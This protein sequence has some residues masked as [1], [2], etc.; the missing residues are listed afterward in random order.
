VRVVP[1]AL[2]TAIAVML[3]VAT[4]PASGAAEKKSGSASFDPSSWA[5]GSTTTPTFTISNA[6]SSPNQLGSAQLC[7]PNGF[8]VAGSI[9][10]PAGSP[11]ST[12]NVY[13]FFNL[14]IAPGSSKSFDLTVTVPCNASA[15]SVWKL[16]AKQSNDFNGPPGNN[17]DPYPFP[18]TVTYTGSCTLSFFTQP[19]QSA[20]VLDPST[21]PLTSYPLT[22]ED[23]TSSIQVRAT[24]EGGAPIA[25]VPVTITSTAS[26]TSGGG[27]TSTNGSG[28]ASFPNL[29]VGP[30][31]GE[32]TLTASAP[33]F[34][35]ATSNGFFV[36]TV[37]C[38]AS[39][40][41]ASKQVDSSTNVSVTQ[42]GFTGPIGILVDT[43]GSGASSFCGTGGT[44]VGD[45][46]RVEIR[47]LAGNTEITWRYT[48][49]KRLKVPSN[50]Q[51]YELCV[52]SKG[53]GTFPVQSAYDPDH[54]GRANADPF[55]PGRY[56]GVLTDAP[57][58]TKCDASYT[59]PYPTK[60]AEYANG[61]DAIQVACFPAPFDPKGI[62]VG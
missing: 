8:T 55:D 58:S 10:K 52:G 17:F 23:G 53:G 25:G 4:G 41:T 18:I 56:W 9:P 48:K 31:G 44:T 36:F 7:I 2:M 30:D 50:G 61:A 37:G 5:R 14:A 39:P 15:D 62:G 38:T 29:R 43:D 59:I 6:A 1:I 35:S 40:C 46:F 21:S 19:S 32:Y 47:P 28:I 24:T 33:G 34:T 51:T 11:C 22:A 16:Y 27:A 49:D 54:D 57:S 20:N 45:D 3:V 26:T 13:A 12:T 60:I 42:S